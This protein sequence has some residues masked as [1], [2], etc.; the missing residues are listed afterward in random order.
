MTNTIERTRPADGRPQ[1]NR[2]DRIL[3]VARLHLVNRYNVF[4]V[5][6]MILGFIF[7]VNLVVWWII[8]AS[9]N[10][11]TDRAD[12]MSGLQYSG[13]SFYIFIFMMFL[14]IQAVSSSFPFALGFSATRR[15]FW[16]GTSLTFV[17]LSA[18]YS[19][20]LTVLAGIE[21]ATGGWGFGG[22]MFATF[23][24]GGAEAS[25]PLRFVLYFAT[26]AFFFFTGAAASTIYQRWRMNGMLVL[27]GG[28][29]ILLLG[30]LALV[31]VT[32]SWPLVGAWFAANGAVGV[33][34]WSLVP[35]AIAAVVGY[36]VLRRATPKN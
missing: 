15:D 20:A 22:T 28:L 12:V 2:S 11:P 27:F 21:V 6:W 1:Q 33:V 35:T 30:S 4:I 5:P 29:T 19:A 7:I 18:A 34:L 9:V 14:G 10:S 8:T 26:F 13:A 23:F 24:F 3:S 17:A 25:W 16:I 36:A 31:T 32:S